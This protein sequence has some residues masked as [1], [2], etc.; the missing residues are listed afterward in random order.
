M[1][2]TDLRRASVSLG[3]LLSGGL[4]ACAVLAAPPHHVK[5]RH[6]PPVKKAKPAGSAAMVKMGE[7]VYDKSGCK[8]CHAINGEGGK[9]GPNLTHIAREKGHTMKF[10]ETQVTNPKANYP[11]G[12]MPAFKNIKGK[13]LTALATYLE[14]LK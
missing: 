13:D 14:S 7:S 3:L 12:R 2:R 6:K 4:L 8:N 10:F 9:A 11:H 1:R 5:P